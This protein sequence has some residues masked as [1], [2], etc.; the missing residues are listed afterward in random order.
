MHL[1]HSLIVLMERS[2]SAMWSSVSAMLRSVGSKSCLMH[3]NSWSAST[4]D[5]VNPRASYKW[6]AAWASRSSVFFDRLLMGAIVRN[7]MYSEMVLKKVLQFTP[8]MSMNRRS[9]WSV[10]YTHLTLP[11]IC[12][13]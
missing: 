10:S 12:S 7:L 6:M 8:K 3:L 5:T 1:V 13:V 4:R 2:T 11:T 9:V